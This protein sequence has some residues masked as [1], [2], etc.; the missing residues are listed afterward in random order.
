MNRLYRSGHDKKLFGV[1]GGVAQFL[2][3]DSTLVRLGVIVLTI[4]TGIPI[5]IYLAMAMIV[6]KEPTWVNPMSEFGGEYS[7]NPYANIDKEMEQLEK[8]AMQQE[9]YRLRAELAKYKGL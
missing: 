5:L 2:R 6:P 1:C 7:H 4:F 3:I 9:I 8:R